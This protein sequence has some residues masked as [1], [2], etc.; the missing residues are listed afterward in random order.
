VIGRFSLYGFLK[1]Q[2]YYE[3]FIILAFLEMGLNFTL[4]GMIIAFREIMINIMEIPT[5]VIADL[6]G[7][8]R[9]MILSFVSYIL[10]FATLGTIGLISAAGA[11]P[12]GVL[13]AAIL[14]AMVLYAI[15]DAF[16]TGTHKAI[17][18]AWL[19]LQGRTGEKTKVYGYTRSWSKIGSAVNVV[20]AAVIVAITHSYVLIFF[21][22]L[23]P[24][25]INIANMATYPRELDGAH[26]GSVGMGE[27]LAHFK[28]SLRLPFQNR[29]LGRI[30]LESMSFEGYFTA[31]KDYLQPILQAAAVTV[32]AALFSNAILDD[33][34]Q[35]ALLIGPVYLVLFLLSAVASRKSHLFVR[36]VGTEAQTSHR[37][38]AFLLLV[39][40]VMLPSTLLSLRWLLILCFVFLYMLQN[41]WRP[42]LISRIDEHST[43]E[44]GATILSIESQAKSLGTMVLAPLIGFVVDLAGGATAGISAFWPIPIIGMVVAASFFLSGRRARP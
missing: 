39:F 36:G 25:L 34:Q 38:W 1:N 16:R 10:S 35:A 19:R 22:S 4:I 7:R 32:T 28:A 24:Y 23:V 31:T 13:V 11:L 29:S 6:F 37:L 9:A 14:P 2:R 5:G 15:G 41:V 27:A 3:P 17:I 8:R 21:V 26:H 40:L 43:E 33:S 20:V 44:N 12:T 42:V 30:I 18:F